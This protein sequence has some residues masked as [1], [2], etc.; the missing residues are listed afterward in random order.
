MFFRPGTGK[1]VTIVEA[2]RQLLAH[3]ETARLL[4]CAPNNSAAD[5]LAQKLSVLGASVVLRLNSIT[6]KLSEL[7]ESLRA[8]SIINGNEV[9]AMPTAQDLRKY[10]VVVSTCITAGVPASLGIQRGF[11]S[12]I[13][14]DEAGQA[15]EPTVMV[16]L[17]TL[18]DDKTNIILAGD[19]KQLGPIVHSA[20]ASA[21]GLK[22]SYLARIMDREI[23][24]LEG[25][26]SAGGRGVTCV[27]ITSS[28][29]MLVYP[30]LR[31][32]IKLVRNFRSHPAILEFSN[33]HFYNRELQYCG[34]DALIRSLENS[35]EL[36]KKKFPLIFHGII[37]KDQR[38]AS[39]P[40]FFNIEEATL[41]KKYCLSLVSERKSTTR[42]YGVL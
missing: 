13:F 3:N 39:S 21:L 23:Y 35:D 30:F 17:K 38:E 29:L 27:F 10:R 28:R 12:H 6:R 1:T 37:G 19:N 34:P 18:A 41:V 31:R 32:I 2:M 11:Y 4:V 40:S 7:P 14:V 24:N 42:T 8:F 15:M 16:P 22:T 5:L 20:L 26:S 9:F 33:E 25:K 36:P